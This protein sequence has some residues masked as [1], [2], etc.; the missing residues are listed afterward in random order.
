MKNLITILSSIMLAVIFVL[1]GCTQT[2]SQQ[3]NTPTPTQQTT[4]S[5]STPTPTPITT[6]VEVDRKYNVVNP[7]GDFVPVQTKPLAARLD[8]LDGKTIWVCQTEAD[9][10]IMPALWDRL[11]KEYPKTTW[12]RTITS[13]TAPLRLTSDEQKMA[14]AVIVGNAW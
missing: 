10:V 2:P 3:T 5:T 13:N 7:Q 8:T 12:K 11:Q 9:P 4:T 14:Q 1:S 6:T